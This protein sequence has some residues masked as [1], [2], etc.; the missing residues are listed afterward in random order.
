MKA[1]LPAVYKQAWCYSIQDKDLLGLRL[2]TSESP[3][4]APYTRH[5]LIASHVLLI[6]T[7][8]SIRTVILA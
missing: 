5:A 1:A 7:C 6:P 2:C 8:S 4:A 3:K